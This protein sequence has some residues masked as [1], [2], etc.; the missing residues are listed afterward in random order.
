MIS[1]RTNKTK[2]ILVVIL[3]SV[4]LL[5]CLGFLGYFGVKT[6]RRSLLRV[7]AREA[8]AAED[9]KK[10]EKLLS[11]YVQKDPNSEEDYVRLAQVYRHFGDT[12]REMLCW[13]RA[14][15][16]NP[17]K[18]E[19]RDAYTASAMNARDFWHLYTSLSRR[20]R[21]GENLS[22]K[23]QMLYLI[24]AVMTNRAKDA[25]QSYA[26]M[27]KA[28]PESFRQN[29]LARYAEFLVT[30]NKL[31]ESERSLFIEQGLQSDDSFV[32]LESILFYLGGL[33]SSGQDAD[34]I[35][36]QMVS[37]LKQAAGFNRFAGTPYLANYYFSR[38]KFNSVIEV[39]EPFLEDIEHFPM[40]ILYA[41]SCVYR[42]KPE[43]LKTL[44]DRYR[45]LGQKYRLLVSYFDALYDFSQGTG[46]NDNL[47]KNMQ[48]V[49]EIVQSPLA[50][51]IKLQ[52]ALN[53][54]TLENICNI[55]ETIMK[56]PPFYD[57]HERARSA[58]HHYLRNK[59]NKDPELAGDARIVR[60][61]Q[62]LLML[63]S[64]DPLLMRITISDL[65]KKKLLTRQIL[66]ENLDAFPEDPYLLQVAA[67]FE[68]FN[69]ELER[70]LEYIERFCALDVESSTSFALLHMLALELTGKIDEAAEE[71]AAL[72]DNNEMTPKILYRYF[73]FCIRN[74]RRAELS[75]MADRLEASSVPEVKALTPFFRAEELFHQEK[76]EEALDLLETAQTDQ[77]DF[78]LYAADK[79]SSC[80]RVDQ[81]LSRYLALVGK[82][83]DQRVVLANIAEIQMA[84]GKKDEALSYAKQSWE[85]DQDNG[86]GQF[87]YA[88]MLA[89]NGR[90]Q[91]AEKV[92]KIPNR[93]IEMSNGVKELWTDIMLHCVREDLAKRSF[94]SALDR[95]KHYLIL[96]PDDATFLEFKTHAEQELK[97][98]QNSRNPEQ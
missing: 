63:G 22:S 96:F 1:E 37:M 92:L 81:A 76:K 15:S 43:K 16:L 30:T 40:S 72:V 41:E 78:A 65:F 8:F 27:I 55:F 66:E 73:E 60:L 9:W 64:Q 32:R 89:V 23:D 48:K 67:E 7:E 87:V 69:G 14:S 84:R 24:C 52:I 82:Q 31:T 49:G 93:A 71:Y 42:A 90:Y 19:Y 46:N 79:F 35:D 26:R 98:A 77:P 34:S 86:I 97:K 94:Q 2:I 56:T 17:L 45:T 91:D 58:V 54:D 59:I 6:M 57:L 39:L 51:L 11:E 4:V 28:D 36:E 29:D 70:C 95:A 25:E 44:A 83:A 21:L 12:N 20:I 18:P 38:F 80:G 3:I 53:N 10:A 68:L 75:V 74:E 13:Y 47:A 50:N 5:T 62:L 85:T 33:R 61:A 88:Q